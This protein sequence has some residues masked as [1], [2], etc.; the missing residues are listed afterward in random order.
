MAKLISIKKYTTAVVVFIFPIA[1]TGCTNIK[2]DSIRNDPLVYAPTPVAIKTNVVSIESGRFLPE[3]IKVDSGEIVIF[4]NFDKSHHLVVSD[5]HPEHN[6]LPD[7]YSQWLTLNE[8]YRYQ[9]DKVGTYGI[10][11]EDNPSVSAK[12][13]VE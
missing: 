9:F 7:L 5:P 3:I 1:L 2:V 4:T 6:Q 8:S 10:H 12:I 13:L 11:L